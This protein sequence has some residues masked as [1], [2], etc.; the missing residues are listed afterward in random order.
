MNAHHP[1]DPTAS[2]DQT[3]VTLERAP[4]IAGEIV[5]RRSGPHHEIIS[6]GVFLMDTRDGT[7]ERLLVTAALDRLT[8]PADILIGGL[9]VGFSLTAATHHPHTATITV[10]EREPAVIAWHTT[11]LRPHTHGAL[12]DPRVHLENAD[13]TTWLR[14]TTRTF[15]ALCLDID[16][17]PDWTVTD[18]NADLY[19]TDG[20]DLLATRLNPH[21]ILAVWSAAASPAFERRLRSRFT[22]ITA[23]PVPAAH[24]EPDLVYLARRT[25]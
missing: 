24:G 15:D 18:D 16:N 4:G 2:T 14:T 3:P 13:L 5:L 10:I 9:G 7:S 19:D 6:N 21:G 1:Y 23:H 12:D 11:H 22:D 25:P 17:G 8:P 20:L